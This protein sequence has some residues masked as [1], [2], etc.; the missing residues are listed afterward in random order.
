MI[1]RR[2]I[3]HVLPTSTLS[4][5]RSRLKFF[6]EATGQDDPVYLDVDAAR[7]A[8]H[9]D[10]PVPPTFLF[11]AG[12][13]SGGQ[14]QWARQAEVPV[15]KMLHGEQVFTYHRVVHAGETV[16][17]T[18]RVTDIYDKKQG[19]LEFVVFDTGVVDEHSEPVAELRTVMIVRHR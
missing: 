5:D 15:G 19:A 4:L 11:A 7:R 6:A 18:T 9:P 2:W 10:L 1:D 17:A 14:W 12:L 16:V 13:E 3:G 8:G